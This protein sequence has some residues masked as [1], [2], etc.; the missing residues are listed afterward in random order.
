ME[1]L[2]LDQVYSIKPPCS[3]EILGGIVYTG[4]PYDYARFFYSLDYAAIFFRNSQLDTLEKRRAIP[5]RLLQRKR[6][7]KPIEDKHQHIYL[8]RTTRFLT[9]ARE[10]RPCSLEDCEPC[11]AWRKIPDT[12]INGHCWRSIGEFV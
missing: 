10:Y 9:S 1:K 7:F 12:A 11:I 6:E 3:D 4:K 8:M 2:D 5:N